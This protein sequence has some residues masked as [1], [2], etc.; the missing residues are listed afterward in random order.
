M[1]QWISIIGF[2]A[3]IGAILLHALSFPLG[4]SPRF[5]LGSLI[6]EKVHLF[7]LL[8]PEQKL[9][10]PTKFRRFVF[11]LG[12]FSFCILLATGFGPLL[13]GCRLHG[14]LL[15]IHATFARSSSDVP[16]WWRFWSSRCRSR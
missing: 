16:R 3:V 8:F 9:N 7:T 10:W 13:F 4:Y 15:M 11:V 5:S 14:Y 1:F 12:L 6:R 2:V